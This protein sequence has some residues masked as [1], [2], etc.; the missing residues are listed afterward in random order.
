M[1]PEGKGRSAETEKG[2]LRANGTRGGLDCGRRP[3]DMREMATGLSQVMSEFPQ[4]WVPDALYQNDLGQVLQL[5]VPRLY[6]R[7]TNQNLR[8]LGPSVCT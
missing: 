1:G 4:M 5:Q 7:P 3:G 6:P 2:I 8:V